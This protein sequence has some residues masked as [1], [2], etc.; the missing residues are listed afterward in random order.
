MS[1]DEYVPTPEQQVWEL[2]GMFGVVRDVRK[3]GLR[4]W[5]AVTDDGANETV[6]RRW[7][8]DGLEHAWVLERDERII[9][10]AKE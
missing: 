1:M 8:W 3:V 9:T 4:T 10:P 7:T 6:A 2:A 5:E